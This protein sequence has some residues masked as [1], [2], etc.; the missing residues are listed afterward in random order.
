MNIIKIN[1]RKTF[2]LRN[3][4]RSSS[5]SWNVNEINEYDDHV[6]VFL[7]HSFLRYCVVCL[8]QSIGN[9]FFRRVFTT[10]HRHPPLIFKVTEWVS[11]WDLNLISSAIHLMDPDVLQ[12]RRICSTYNCFSLLFSLS[13]S[14]LMD[15]ILNRPLV[16]RSLKCHS[17]IKRLISTDRRRVIIVMTPWLH[18]FPYYNQ[19]IVSGWRHCITFGI[20]WWNAIALSPPK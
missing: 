6:V 7:S 16:W 11:E 18:C 12:D 13:L 10:F 20:Y 17:F 19:L 1:W 8:S 5:V 9:L 3:F 14:A 4:W 15:Y 2:G